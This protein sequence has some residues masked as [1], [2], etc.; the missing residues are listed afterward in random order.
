MT[1]GAPCIF[2]GKKQNMTPKGIPVY[3]A[4]V[5][6]EGTGM[7]KIS[8]VDRPAVESDF[9]ALA[10]QAR[11]L[12][13]R[14]EDEERRLVRGVVM[15]ADFPIY[16]RNEDGSEYYIV[17]RADTIREMAE[18]YLLESRQNAVNLQHEDGTDTDGVHMVQW[19]V[20]DTAAGMAPE[21]FDGIADGSLFAEF[22]VTDDEIWDAVKEGTYKG[23]SL[24]G[25]FELRP[26]GVT[27]SAQARA[28]DEITELYANIEDMGRLS[29]IKDALRKV[30]QELG[31]VST[32][33]GTLLWD[34]EEDLRAGYEV[35]VES[36][37][38]RTPAPDGDYRTEDG[39]V[40]RVADGKVEEI[41]DNA[42]EVA[43]S[44]QDTAPEPAKTPAQLVAEMLSKS[45]DEK[46]SLILN[47]VRRSLG[48]SDCFLLE[49]GDD[50]AIAASLDENFDLKYTR[51]SIAWEG[52][53]P[54]AGEG[55]RVRPAYIPYDME[56]T[57]EAVQSERDSLRAELEQVRTELEALRKQ[58][59]ANP[60]HE[61]VQASSEPQ[62][63][64]IKSLDRLARYM[65][66]K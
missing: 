20:K 22:H 42:A 5:D 48:T 50:Y 17:Y 58:P 3:E 57:F 44:A 13:Y 2:T 39:K 7:F 4:L 29:R 61:E 46:Q 63:T 66:A 36:D 59:L 55:Q 1:L 64:G 23:F 31:S 65:A 35:Y 21:G 53:T 19:F 56:V 8:L 6:G 45:Y 27:L 24:E 18:K 33:R 38:E 10:A 47:A 49:C 30:L 28:R 40:I 60:A 26:E 25:V 32:D 16:R 11:A 62:K 14:V 37:G 54:V 52:D 51:Y 9:I 41:T 34:G 15:R 43:A 12:S